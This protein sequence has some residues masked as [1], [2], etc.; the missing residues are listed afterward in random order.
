MKEMTIKIGWILLFSYLIT[1]ATAVVLISL[2]AVALTVFAGTAYI[3]GD[4]EELIKNLSDVGINEDT[5]IFIVQTA[6]VWL[7]LAPCGF[8]LFAGIELYQYLCE[9]KKERV[10][11]KSEEKDEN[12]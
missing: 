3:G 4:S 9:R 11:I 1:T 6:R 8:L 12:N 10:D 2:L 7:F 5:I